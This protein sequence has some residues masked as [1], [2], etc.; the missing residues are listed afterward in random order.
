MPG[1]GPDPPP[2]TLPPNYRCDVGWAGYGSYCYQVQT[3]WQTQADARTRCRTL[4]GDLVSIHDINEN[5]FVLN[6]M[7]S[8]KSYFK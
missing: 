8:G 2:A 5:D 7:A 6:L 3:L 4:G 1:V